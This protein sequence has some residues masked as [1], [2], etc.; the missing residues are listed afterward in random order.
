MPVES[1]RLDVAFW[2]VRVWG[3]TLTDHLKSLELFERAKQFLAGGVSSQFR[4]SERPHPLFYSRAH[5]SHIWDIDGNE[6]LDFSLSQGPMILGHSRPVVIEAV[7]KALA[8]GQLFGRQ[9]L[10][11]LEPRNA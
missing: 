3:K 10:A 2:A 6:Y 11:E 9:H 1:R 4:A 7:R 5:G 8:D